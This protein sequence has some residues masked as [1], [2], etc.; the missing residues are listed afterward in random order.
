MKKAR[1]FGTRQRAKGAALLLALLTAAL[2]A[3]FA[4]AAL[5][6]QWRS[7]EVEAAERARIQASWVLRGSLDW[8]RLILRE[9]ARS[10]GIDHLGEP[11]AVPLQEA[12]LSAFLAGASNVAVDAS[13]DMLEAFISGRII[14]L[15]SRLN[16]SNLIENSKI[17]ETDARSFQRLFEILSLPGGE[18]EKVI[19][20][21]LLASQAQQ[22]YQARSVPLMPQRLEHLSWL[23]A[24]PGT[25][26]A[27]QP[28][29]TVLPSRSAVNL[30]TASAE[31]IYAVLDGI[32]AGDA[33]RL[34]AEREHSPF[35]TIGDA[36]KLIVGSDLILGEGQA[37]IGVASRFFEVRARLRLDNLVVEQRAVVQ[38]DGLSVQTLENERV[39]P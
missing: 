39:L 1:P 26:R 14:D 2:V 6:Q 20:N 22:G 23:G 21:V 30:N 13:P 7:I 9:D 12:K 11:W 36:R 29:V 16:V 8:A 10:G 19:A 27:L 31:V 28:Y 17:S 18:L 35:R 34:I 37:G 25:V 33:H 32:R 4:A 5:W 3:T 15:H 24:S 38:R